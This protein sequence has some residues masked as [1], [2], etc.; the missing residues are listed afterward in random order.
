[1]HIIEVNFGSD[2]VKYIIRLHKD[3]F[4]MRVFQ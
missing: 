4:L 3:S 2:N 1:M